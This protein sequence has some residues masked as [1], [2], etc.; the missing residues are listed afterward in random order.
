MGF[1]VT[2]AIDLHSM[3]SFWRLLVADDCKGSLADSHIQHII[4]VE[5]LELVVKRACYFDFV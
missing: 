1:R 2:G 4:A 5:R 3:L